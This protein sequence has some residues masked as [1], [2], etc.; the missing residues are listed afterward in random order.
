MY[1]RIDT[2]ICGVKKTLIEWTSLQRVTYIP[3]ACSLVLFG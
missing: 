1:R 2:Q 3:V